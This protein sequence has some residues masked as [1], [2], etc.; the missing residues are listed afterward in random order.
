MFAIV[1]LIVDHNYRI[2]NVNAKFPG[3]AHDAHIW[4]MS[5]IRNHLMNVHRN[6]HEWL[7]GDIP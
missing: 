6:D 7:L 3:S 2:L 1:L 5:M 4:K